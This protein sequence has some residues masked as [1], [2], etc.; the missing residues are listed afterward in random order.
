[1]KK[2]EKKMSNEEETSVIAKETVKPELKIDLVNDLETA[3]NNNN[4]N[5]TA[6]D[7][8]NDAGN[9]SIFYNASIYSVEQNESKTIESNEEAAVETEQQQNEEAEVEKEEEEEKTEVDAKPAVEIVEDVTEESEKTEIEKVESVEVIAAEPEK[10]TEK[11]SV[12]AEEEEEPKD[13]SKEDILNELKK[14]DLESTGFLNTTDI[15]EL[16]DKLQVNLKFESDD[17]NKKLESL[18]KNENG[19]VNYVEL[20]NSL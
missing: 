8:L 12:A 1:L 4:N 2:K 11:E 16:A 13:L 3:E 15:K 10:D 20:V 17:L 14:L 19:Q 9:S 7:T 6:E 5:S 18:E